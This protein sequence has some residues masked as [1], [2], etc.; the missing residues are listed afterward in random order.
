M[1][2]DLF[3]DHPYYV[4]MKQFASDDFISSGYVQGNFAALYK[5]LPYASGNE[6]FKFYIYDNRETT[7]TYQKQLDD[8][9]SQKAYEMI[10]PVN[11]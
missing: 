9:K 10:K 1:D 4:S 3:P 2:T 6:S 7:I 5:A 11:E 8:L